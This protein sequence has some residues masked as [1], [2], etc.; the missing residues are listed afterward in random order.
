MESVPRLGF[1]SVNHQQLA[2]WDWPGADPPLL[3][4]H[5]T[6]FHGRCWDSIVR[7]FPGRHAIALEAVAEHLNL[8][9]AIGV[10]HSMGGHLTVQ[11]AALRPETYQALLLVDPT[12]FPAEFYGADPPDA[13]FILRRR[14]VWSSPSEMFERFRNRPPF[15]RWQPDILHSYCDWGLLPSGSEYLLACPP[16]IEASIYWNS[17]TPESNIYPEIATI[18]QPVIVMRAG[19]VRASGAFD[20]SASPTAIDLASKFDRGRDILLPDCSHYIPM[21][22]PDVV[23]EAIRQLA[24]GQAFL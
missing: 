20:L 12:I 18:R 9:D 5:A 13:A 4:A 21:E 24:G 8:R 11:A 19:A 1:I 14:A 17:R 2:I 22:R 16:P 15:Q 23:A 6:G 7:L 10:G 3:F